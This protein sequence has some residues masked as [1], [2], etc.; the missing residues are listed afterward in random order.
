MREDEVDIKVTL[1]LHV[2]TDGFKT[3]KAL[4]NYFTKYFSDVAKNYGKLI[5]IKVE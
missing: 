2:N 5:S 1:V 4:L 3:E